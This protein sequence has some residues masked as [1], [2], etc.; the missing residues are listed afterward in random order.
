MKKIIF[1]VCL[2]W[3]PLYAETVTD[4]VGRKVELSLPVTRIVSLSPAATEMIFAMGA[5]KTL[6]AVSSFCDYPEAA[7]KIEKAGSFEKPDVEK[8]ISLNPQLVISG[9]GVQKAA[10]SKLQKA[11]IPVIVLYPRSLKQIDAQ[12]SMLGR[13]TGNSVQAL[14]VGERMNKRINAV[15]AK[16]YNKSTR[17]YVE[18]WNRPAMTIGSTSYLNEIIQIAG[19]DNVYA[20][21]REE[22]PRPSREAITKLKPQAIFLLYDAGKEDLKRPEFKATEAFR[23]NKI[24]VIKGEELDAIMRPGPRAAEAAEIFYKYLYGGEKIIEE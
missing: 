6:L 16:T 15:K 24:F 2:L 4:S 18:I 7:K 20:V 22:Y 10:I 21:S 1:F 23:G 11:G 19:G 13:I 12:I 9:G 14:R 17:V 5:E 8:I 3:A